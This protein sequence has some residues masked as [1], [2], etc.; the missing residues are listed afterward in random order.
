MLTSYPDEAVYYT[1]TT[2]LAGL[3]GAGD[4]LINDKNMLVFTTDYGHLPPAG[5]AARG[6]GAPE[7]SRAAS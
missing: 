7:M 1:N 2:G 3:A 4:P 5:T 6:S